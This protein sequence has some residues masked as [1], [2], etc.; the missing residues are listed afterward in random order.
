MRAD[1][2]PPRA[3]QWTV[4][5]AS[6]AYALLALLPALLAAMVARS[7]LAGVVMIMLPMYFVIGQTNAIANWHHRAPWPWSSA[8]RRQS[9]SCGSSIGQGGGP[10]SR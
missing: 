7:W 3:V 2:M 8:T 10:R 4:T 9:G 5:I 1:I 6:L